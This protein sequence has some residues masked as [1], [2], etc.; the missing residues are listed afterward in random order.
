MN[1]NQLGAFLRA[2]AARF[3]SLLKNSRVSRASP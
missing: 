1:P 2:E 3:N